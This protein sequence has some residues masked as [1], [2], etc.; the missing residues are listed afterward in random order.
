VGQPWS[1]ITLNLGDLTYGQIDFIDRLRGW[2]RICEQRRLGSGGQVL[3]CIYH[4]YRTQDGGLSW[5]QLR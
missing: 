3:R 2:V 1:K 5:E 4:D